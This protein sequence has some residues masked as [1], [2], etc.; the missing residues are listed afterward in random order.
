[1]PPG[2]DPG[3]PGSIGL[4]SFGCGEPWL[5]H[6]I[7]EVTLGGVAGG[8]LG[9]GGGLA[10]ITTMGTSSF[11]GYSGFVVAYWLLGG[12]VVG[13]VAGVWMGVRRG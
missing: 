4:S 2:P 1:M 7:F 13:I 9:L 8:G 6:G 5:I 3:K 10:W 12:I 11:E